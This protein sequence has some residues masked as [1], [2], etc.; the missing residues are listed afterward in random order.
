MVVT[1][2]ERRRRPHLRRP[3]VLGR[4]AASA[5][6]GAAAQATHEGQEIQERQD[7]RGRRST[8]SSAH[9]E[10]LEGPIGKRLYAT[11]RA[12][13][14]YH[15]VAN[16]PTSGATVASRRVSPMATTLIW[17]LQERY[18]AEAEVCLDW[19]HV[20]EKLWAAGECLH[21]E[22]LQEL[23]GSR[24]RPRSCATAR[25]MPS[26]ACSAT[27]WGGFRRP[28][29]ATAEGER[30][31]TSSPILVKNRRIG[32]ATRRCAAATSTSAAA[33]PREPSATSSASAST[34]PTRWS[35][36]AALEWPLHLRCI[37]LNGSGSNS[38]PTSPV[39]A[40]SSSGRS[41]FPLKRMT[42]KQRHN[43]CASKREN[44][45]LHLRSWRAPRSHWCWC[46]C[47]GPRFS[48][49][50]EEANHASGRFFARRSTARR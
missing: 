41:Q 42:R 28:D 3:H 49:G 2:G 16:A 36:R 21:A 18:F 26:S 45:D 20:V 31:R 24:S 7:G 13:R 11:S 44:Q 32:C 6:K 23:N 43:A 4:H 17:R 22:G 27:S 8:R 12:T 19:W 38:L 46:N 37:L 50:T 10:G 35:S 34:V 5:A 25:P 15:L 9:S 39:V 30:P 1:V 29:W 40:T 47:S 33:P 48:A 14:R